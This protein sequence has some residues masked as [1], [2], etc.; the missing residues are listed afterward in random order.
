[1]GN[2][3]NIFQCN[4]T[5]KTLFNPKIGQSSSLYILKKNKETSSDSLSIPIVQ[6]MN[7]HTDNEFQSFSTNRTSSN[8]FS[9]TQH[10]KCLDNFTIERKLIDDK[11]ND[12]S[13]ML[14]RSKKDHSQLFV[15]KI[16]ENSGICSLNEES[17]LQYLKSIGH[18]PYIADIKQNFICFSKLYLI[19]EYC[20]G[21]KLIEVMRK[22]KRFSED[23]SRFYIAE[24]ILALEKLENISQHFRYLSLE[25]LL[26]DQDGHLKIANF[27]GSKIFLDKLIVP[28]ETSEEEQSFPDGEGKF[29]KMEQVLMKPNQKIRNLEFLEYAAPEML[30]RHYVTTK[31][32]D[33]WFLGVLLYQMVTG[34]LPFSIRKIVGS[35]LDLEFLEKIQKNLKENKP[36]LPNGISNE[37]KELMS[38]LLKK[39]HG[40]RLGSNG[41]RELRAHSFFDKVLWKDLERKMIPAP[42]SVNQQ[43]ICLIKQEKFKKFWRIQENPLR[44]PDIYLERT[45]F[46][47]KTTNN[48]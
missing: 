21:G 15:M 8:Q 14:M 32:S 7:P 3:H 18:H 46:I 40:D 22:Q 29:S 45:Y 38:K 42:Y 11:S 12:S 35:G 41:W 10:L 1:M 43:I 24:I 13:L 47:G 4:K 31:N 25:N 28:E 33:F 23:V 37:C 44:K 26:L 48:N 34:E 19:M 6:T 9:T 27:G 2:N 36:K 20:S 30:E 5:S 17:Y 39:N 16:V